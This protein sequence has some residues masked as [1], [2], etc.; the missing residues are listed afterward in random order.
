MQSIR[1]EPAGDI[2]IAPLFAEN[3]FRKDFTVSERKALGEA[4]RAGGGEAWAQRYTGAARKSGTAGALRITMSG[5][6][7][8]SVMAESPECAMTHRAI[9]K[10]RLHLASAA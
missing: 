9:C 4:I 6:Q 2:K 10:L 7:L 8:S 3:V 1:R 5:P